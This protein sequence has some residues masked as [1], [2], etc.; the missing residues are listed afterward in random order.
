VYHNSKKRECLI[1]Q[2]T[3]TEGLHKQ[4]LIFDHT[5]ITH[6]HTHHSHTSTGHSIH[7]DLNNKS[8]HLHHTCPYPPLV[9][10][11]QHT[12]DGLARHQKS[13]NRAEGKGCP[14]EMTIATCFN[15][16]LLVGAAGGGINHEMATQSADQEVREH[17][18]LRTQGNVCHDDAEGQCDTSEILALAKFAH[19]T[20]YRN[21]RTHIRNC[22]P[23]L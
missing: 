2:G 5:S 22:N 18:R 3:Y 12:Q 15:N 11:L 8:A 17:L 9:Q 6:T 16:L 21:G 14:L 10:L 23:N 19:E 7:T 13:A 4:L 1:F 20:R